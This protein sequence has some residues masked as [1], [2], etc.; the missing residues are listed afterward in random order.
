MGKK[1]ELYNVV[2]KFGNSHIFESIDSYQRFIKEH[3]DYFFDEEPC[4]KTCE[5]A[6]E[7]NMVERPPHYASRTYEVIDVMRDTQTLERHIGFLEGQ[8]IKYTMRWDKKDNPLQDL[9]KA[10]WYLN[11]LIQTIKEEQTHAVASY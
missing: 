2:D 11:R 5:I 4:K 10:K 1:K 9:E 6:P 8:I 7:P 3:T